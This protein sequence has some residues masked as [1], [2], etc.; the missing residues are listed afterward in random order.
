MRR[1]TLFFLAAIFTSPPLSAAS[2]SEVFGLFASAPGLIRDK[3]QV[4]DDP[5]AGLPTG[6]DDEGGHGKSGGKKPRLCR[7][8]ASAANPREIG[9]LRATLAFVKRGLAT[10]PCP[11]RLAENSEIRLRIAADGNGKITDVEPAG[12]DSGTAKALAKRLVGQTTAPRLDRATV[13]TT[14]LKFAGG[15]R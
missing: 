13:G 4:P 8:D 14:V 12:G 3:R 10:W 1:T 9:D 15:K 7:I 2:S 5:L 11:P 6:T